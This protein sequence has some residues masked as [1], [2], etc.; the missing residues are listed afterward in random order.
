MWTES[1]QHAIAAGDAN[2]ALDW[3]QN[4]TTRLVMVTSLLMSSRIDVSTS[5]KDSSTTVRYS[6]RCVIRV[7]RCSPVLTDFCCMTPSHGGR[8]ARQFCGK[9]F[10]PNQTVSDAR[11]MLMSDSP[12]YRSTAMASFVRNISIKAWRA[13]APK[14]QRPSR[15]GS[16]IE[17]ALRMIR[18]RCRSRHQPTT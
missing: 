7:G 3:M 17:P 6:R 5:L 2:R 12:K 13:L 10:Y 1:I 14:C 9:G 18:L 4:C 11:I 8:R 15:F 16:A